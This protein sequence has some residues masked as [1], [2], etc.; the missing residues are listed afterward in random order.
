VRALIGLA[1]LGLAA[2]GGGGGATTAPPAD[3]P[4]VVTQTPPPVVTDD[5]PA[6]QALIAAGGTIQLDARTYHYNKA[7]I[8]TL[9][10][11][12]LRGQTG[13]VLEFQSPPVG[14]PRE[15]GSNDR[16]IGTDS[17]AASVPMQIAQSIAVGDTQFVAAS[18]EDTAGLAAGDW[19]VITV[20]DP[21][22]A[23]ENTHLG[24]P[25][26]IDW[27]QVAAVE[28]AVVHTVAPFRMAFPNTLP[29]V[30]NDSG[31]GFVRVRL[32]QNL[33][34]ENL[35]I[36][37]DA[38]APVVGVY[39]LGTLNTTLRNVT[40]IDPT[41]DA[42]YTEESKGT[43]IIDCNL[44]GGSVLN[45]FSESVDLT[46][47]GT[48]LSYDTVAIALDL[49]TGFFEV[50]GNT[51]SH[52]GHVAIY[53]FYNVHDGAISGNIIDPITNIN[54]VGTIGVWLHGSPN[55]AVNDN[56]MT[57]PGTTGIQADADPSADIAEPVAGDVATGNVIT[58][59]TTQ[60]SIL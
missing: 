9:S 23:D 25:T 46:I 28:G 55:V 3:P 45:E 56:T 13:T 40:I 17:M 30:P 18:A 24:Y 26:Y 29:F 38:G 5:T 20:N 16:A 49:G 59:Y 53:G 37:V 1:V 48:T 60:V 14:T 35:T 4:P 21:G 57:G 10:G 31:L 43:A 51:I 58:G 32:M 39:V 19:V 44:S 50:S 52:S 22:V 54:N 27:V 41:S 2:C 42:V 6:L 15:A 12:T 36:K 47:S 11:T 8:P 33:T 34:I 7:L